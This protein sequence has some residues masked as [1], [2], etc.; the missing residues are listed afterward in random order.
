MLSCYTAHFSRACA[1]VIANKT[2]HT[3][4]NILLR[5]RRKKILNFWPLL[6]LFCFVFGKRVILSSACLRIPGAAWPPC[7]P[8]YGPDRASPLISK[9]M[10]FD[11]DPY[12][13]EFI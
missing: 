10:V 11:S 8:G 1:Q 3:Y 13:V 4:I 9:N 6:E 7:P 2:I 12:Y 5:Q